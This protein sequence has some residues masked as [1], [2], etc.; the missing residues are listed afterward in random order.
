VDDSLSSSSSEETREDCRIGE[1]LSWGV[2][3]GRI[4]G[5]GVGRRAAGRIGSW[6][7][8]SHRGLDALDSLGWIEREEA[9]AKQP[10]PIN[11]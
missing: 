4:V 5:V 3:D 9:L 2:I 10:K 8:E 1:L 7:G 6:S 11:R